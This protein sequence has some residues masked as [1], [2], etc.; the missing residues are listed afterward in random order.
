MSALYD[1]ALET[2]VTTNAIEFLAR[3][4]L[5]LKIAEPDVEAAKEAIHTPAGREAAAREF[6]ALTDAEQVDLVREVTEHWAIV[7]GLDPGR[8]DASGRR[9]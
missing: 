9:C 3:A 1:A 4:Q 6:D 2:V 8:V 7:I 5:L